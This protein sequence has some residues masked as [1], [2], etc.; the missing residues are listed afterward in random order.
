MINVPNYSNPIL[1]NIL[2]SREPQGLGQHEKSFPDFDDDETSSKEGS[3]LE[4][5]SAAQ[6]Q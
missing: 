4:T 2:T 5:V 3:G 1:V 6:I